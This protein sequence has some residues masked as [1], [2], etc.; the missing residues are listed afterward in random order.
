[1]GQTFF[2]PGIACVP[3]FYEPA[4]T[5]RS[6]AL[7]PGSGAGAQSQRPIE[8]SYERSQVGKKAICV[9]F[10]DGIVRMTN[11]VTAEITNVATESY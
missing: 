2:G 9:S 5:G 4:E 7:P 11:K 8:G 3:G 1:M 10:C 6:D